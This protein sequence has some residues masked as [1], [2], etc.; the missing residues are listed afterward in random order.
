MQRLMSHIIALCGEVSENSC[1]HSHHN[2]NNNNHHSSRSTKKGVI[3]NVTKAAARKSTL[4]Q[5][6]RV[7]AANSFHWTKKQD[8]HINVNRQNKKNFSSSRIPQHNG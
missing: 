4:M 2:Y 7:K 5:T 6:T 3:I 1:N 8:C